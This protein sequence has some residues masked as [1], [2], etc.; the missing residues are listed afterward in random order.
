MKFRSC[1]CR[2]SNHSHASNPTAQIVQNQTVPG[3]NIDWKAPEHRV[4]P[5]ETPTSAELR[6][7]HILDPVSRRSSTS[8]MASGDEPLP[9]YSS[10]PNDDLLL[11][12][13]YDATPTQP[14]ISTPSPRTAGDSLSVPTILTGQRSG[15][16]NNAPASGSTVPDGNTADHNG[17]CTE[18][19]SNLAASRS[20]TR[21][22]EEEDA[23]P[24]HPSTQRVK[25]K[26]KSTT[27]APPA[28]AASSHAR[29]VMVNSGNI[30][31]VSI[32]ECNNSTL[33][34][35]NGGNTNVNESKSGRTRPRTA[36]RR[37]ECSRTK[38]KAVRGNGS[39]SDVLEDFED[40]MGDFEDAMEN[41]L[42]D[43]SSTSRRRTAESYQGYTPPAG[44]T[45]ISPWGFWGLSNVRRVS[46]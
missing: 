25:K 2:S 17:R 29:V 23:N 11:T 3:A 14:R 16:A 1:F 20:S 42:D 18:T 4:K 12:S 5:T 19:A 33:N 31:N 21:R 36:G 15:A 26:K 8:A 45:F 38:R 6:V 35:S 37:F 43:L 28:S 32:N 27:S 40:A 41:I 7:E 46:P 13:S 9:L 10:S 44:Q 34:F 24:A 39:D 30:R 22:E